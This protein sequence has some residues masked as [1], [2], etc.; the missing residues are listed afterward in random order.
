MLKI[1]L[2]SFLFVVACAASAYA[3]I[4]YTLLDQQ[5]SGESVERGATLAL[6]LTV[7]DV[8]I[9]RGSFNLTETVG[10]PGTINIA[11]DVSDFVAISWAVGTNDNGYLTP[12]SGAYTF[13]S[14]SLMFTNGKPAGTLKLTG[15]TS[16]F[17]LSGEAEIFT[18]TLASDFSNCNDLQGR[19]RCFV[20]GEL[21]ESFNVPEPAATMIFVPVLLPLL[22]GR[23]RARPRLTFASKTP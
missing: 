8:A 3:S 7:S 9:Q 18:G 20:T 19:S 11:G 1:V 23:H 22:L 10:S 12:V 4:T 2:S 17:F 5:Y 21:V 16:E 6:N 14:T 13:F 15:E